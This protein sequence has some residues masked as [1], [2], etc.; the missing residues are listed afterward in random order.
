[1]KQIGTD[2]IARILNDYFKCKL[3]TLKAIPGF[4]II[5]IGYEMF[6][7][8]LLILLFLMMAE[9]IKSNKFGFTI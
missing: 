2:I 1:M 6:E 3:L 9:V 7:M 8:V 5:S 4:N